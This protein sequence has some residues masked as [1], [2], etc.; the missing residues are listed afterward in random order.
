VPNR[1]LLIIISSMAASLFFGTT[2]NRAPSKPLSLISSF[3]LAPVDF[4]EIPSLPPDA[5]RPDFLCPEGSI[6]D[7]KRFYPSRKVLGRLFRSIPTQNQ[8]HED[9]T[10][11]SPPVDGQTISE[12]LNRLRSEFPQLPDLPEPSDELWTEMVFILH[13]Y[14]EQL[15]NISITHSLSRHRNHGLTEAE[16]VT[17]TIESSWSNNQRGRQEAATAM[18]FQASGIDICVFESPRYSQRDL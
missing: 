18:N 7:S 3:A 5:L 16:L 8:N 17:G 9:E 6:P 2:S 12:A 11:E 14:A 1:I 10:R 15:S 13:Q 4:R